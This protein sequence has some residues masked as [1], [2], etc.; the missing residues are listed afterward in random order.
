MRAAHAAEWDSA[1]QTGP[2]P[3][4]GEGLP[5]S[6]ITISTLDEARASEEPQMAAQ[7]LQ[8]PQGRRVSTLDDPEGFDDV[9]DGLE[10]EVESAGQQF[11]PLYEELRDGIRAWGSGGMIVEQLRKQAIDRAP[12]GTLVHR[13][14]TCKRLK[15]RREHFVPAALR[16]CL[17][18]KPEAGNAAMERAQFPSMAQL[19]PPATKEATFEW[20][21]RPEGGTI[22][23]GSKV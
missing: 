1:R 20:V 2:S 16:H 19:I 13:I 18:Q 11:A 6:P 10:E 8:Q 4:S 22:P 7:A 9:E 21:T 12:T 23:M 3:I 17:T 5:S 15:A 14:W